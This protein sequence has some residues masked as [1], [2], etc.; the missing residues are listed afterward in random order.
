MLSGMTHW[1]KVRN[2]KRGG[3]LG[4]AKPI[5]SRIK[6]LRGTGDSTASGLAASLREERAWTG[7]GVKRV[8][9]LERRETQESNVLLTALI[10]H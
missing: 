9:S 4:R 1:E 7:S 8:N 6:P 10:R 3:R 2:L 5:S